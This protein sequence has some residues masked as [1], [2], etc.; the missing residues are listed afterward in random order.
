MAQVLVRDLDDLTV[1]RLKHRARLH[2]RPLEAE[3]RLILTQAAQPSR[4]EVLDDMRRLRAMTPP[5]VAQTDSTA[6]VR[7]ERDTR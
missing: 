4:Q 2:G 7:E 3:L 1:E 6:L 5:G